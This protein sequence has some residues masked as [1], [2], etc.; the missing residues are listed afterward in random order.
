MSQTEF[1]KFKTLSIVILII[2]VVFS[3]SKLAYAS[4]TEGCGIWDIKLE[5]DLSGWM[6]LLMGDIAIGAFLAVL[7]HYFATKNGKQLEL[8]VKEQEIMRTRRRIFSVETLKN[9][10]TTL[11]FI[12]SIID[13]LIF[14]YNK[15]ESNKDDKRQQISRNEEKLTRTISL[16]RDTVLFSSDILKPEIVNEVNE[17]CKLAS[18]T[19]STFENDKLVLPNYKRLKTWIFDLSN[20]LDDLGK[21]ESDVDLLVMKHETMNPISKKYN[22]RD[23]K[24]EDYESE[25]IERELKRR[26]KNKKEKN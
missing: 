16:I 24:F 2:F 15:K 11:I 12:Y 14:Q 17:L 23:E 8:I 19:I 9:N 5:C 21:V 26:A 10:F 22:S 6:K 4:V 3:F 1:T 13:T 25:Y 18:D 20:N 7:L